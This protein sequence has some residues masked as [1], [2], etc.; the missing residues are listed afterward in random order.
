M[1][2]KSSISRYNKFILLAILLL[3][4][5]LRV[6]GINWGLPNDDHFYP[7]YADEYTVLMLLQNMNPKELN[8]YPYYEMYDCM[9]QDPMF[10]YYLIGAAEI[11][12]SKLSLITITKDKIF[13]LNNTREYAKLF[14]V[15]RFIS[16]FL[17][18]FTILLIYFIGK[19]IYSEEI[20]LLSAFFLCITPLHVVYS[21]I[22][23]VAVPTTF[24][25]TLAL[26]FLIIAVKTNLLKWYILLGISTGIAI[27]NKYT[28][29][30][31]LLVIFITHYLNAGNKLVSRK[32]ILSYLAVMVAFAITNPCMV[33]YLKDSILLF[34]RRSNMALTTYEKLG[35][36]HPLKPLL[37][38]GMGPSLLMISC[39]GI[40]LGF[41][42]H[43][44]YD[45]ILLTWVI[46]YYSITAYV[47]SDVIRYQNEQL[48]F[49]ILLAAR[50]VFYK[51][52][53]YNKFPKAKY[54]F[55]MSIA[56]IVSI[57]TLTR[58]S[59]SINLLK[60]SDPRTRASQWIIRN[61]PEH[62][63]IGVVEHPLEYFPP[64]INMQY[65]SDT[66]YKDKPHNKPKYN[67][68][69]FDF[70]ADNLDTEKADY[71]IIMERQ[72]KKLKTL[73]GGKQ[74]IYNLDQQYNKIRTF[75][76][77]P[78]LFGIKFT[79]KHHYNWIIYYPKIYIMQRVVKTY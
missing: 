74:F 59:I 31:F 65:Y 33:I 34:L 67:I 21:M 1:F 23:N 40:I 56:I 4:L 36:L 12:A 32:L 49:L 71:I 5:Y 43:N 60:N 42:N 41:F 46:S 77:K 61:I 44:K 63:K 76:V 47:G 25:L 45:V 51:S 8:F 78:E 52:S 9:Y 24:W 22:M 2:E 30:P 64:I 66:R 69:N 58:T 19:M 20:G 55:V 75:Y 62:I 10:N 72:L 7:Y 79:T 16:I 70:S 11:I 17:G 48:P 39:L 37:Y 53:F 35:C 29:F 27:S 50:F 38:N 15:G 57:F 26:F 68:V 13:Y 73:D 28:A 54:I 6:S 3:G 14:I 18:I